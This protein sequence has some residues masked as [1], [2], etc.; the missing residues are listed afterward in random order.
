MKKRGET[1]TPAG[2]EV[3]SMPAGVALVPRGVP[4]AKAMSKILG[5]RKDAPVNKE[6]GRG[7]LARALAAGFPQH[8]ASALARP[9]DDDEVALSGKVGLTLATSGCSHDL[10][11]SYG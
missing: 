11:A 2:G 4:G 10:A 7:S 3:S 9:A 8:R 5:V 6:P 1:P